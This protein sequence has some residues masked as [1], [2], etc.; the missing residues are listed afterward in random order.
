MGE[1]LNVFPSSPLWYLTMALVSPLVVR[2]GIASVEAVRREV[3]FIKIFKGTSG[4]ENVPSDYWLAFILGVGEM[5]SYPLLI[6]TDHA[7][8]IGAWVAFK[9]VNRWHY[10]PGVSRGPYNRYLVANGIILIASYLSARW[11]TI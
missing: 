8:Y 11:F 5:L 2:V 10:A 4:Q 7:L 6:V 3:D 9:T 1:L